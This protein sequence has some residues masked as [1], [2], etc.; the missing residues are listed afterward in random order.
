VLQAQKEISVKK[1]TSSGKEIIHLPANKRGALFSMLDLLS[2]IASHV[3]DTYM[4]VLIVLD[5]IIQGN[6]VIQEKN[7]IQSVHFAII[8]MYNENLI[9]HLHSC[10]QATIKTA[11]HRFAE[12]NMV[13]MQ[14]YLNANGSRVTYFSGEIDKQL[15]AV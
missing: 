10:L 15:K 13:T 6:M 1:D 7:L 9:P 2:E 4:I 14:T 11:L 3:L 5:G 8:D 12:L